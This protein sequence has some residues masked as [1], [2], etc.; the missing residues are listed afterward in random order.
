MR[1]FRMPSPAN[2]AF[3]DDLAAT[4]AFVVDDE[5][6]AQQRDRVLVI[7]MTGR[8]GR[9]AARSELSHVIATINGLA[10]PHNE[11][12][13]HAAGDTLVWR[14]INASLIP[15]PMHLHGFYFDVLTRGYATGAPDSSFTPTE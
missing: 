6:S 12:L 2:P 14:V 9:Q 15:H 13:T 10:W 7:N 4:G 1:S 11:R 3:G 8:S 5:T